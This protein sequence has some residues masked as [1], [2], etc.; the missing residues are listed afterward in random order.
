ME[1]AQMRHRM[2]KGLQSGKRS[3]KSL[4][5][6]KQTIF[7]KSSSKRKDTTVMPTNQ[8]S[9]EVASFRKRRIPRVVW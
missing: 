4:Q 7:I 9:S 1:G 8:A 6:V 2:T 3:K 5:D